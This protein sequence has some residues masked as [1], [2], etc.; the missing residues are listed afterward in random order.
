[1]SDAHPQYLLAGDIGGTHSLLE[2]SE[3]RGDSM[4][5]VHEQSYR[6]QAYPGLDALLDDFLRLPPVSVAAERVHAACFAVAG[7]VEANATRLSNLPWFIDGASLA[8]RYGI[9]QV[10]IVNDFAAVGHGIGELGA[11]ELTT[12]QP[13]AAHPGGTRLAVGAG[14]GLG[15]CL[16]TWQDDRYVVHPSEGG[17]ADFAPTN[18]TQDASLLSLRQTLGHVSYERVV[19]GPGL[20]RI[21]GF[22][23]ESGTGMPSSALL[24]AMQRQDPSAAISEFAIDRRDVLA[25]RALDLFVEIYGA[26][27]GSMALTTLARGGVYLAGGIARKIAHKLV[28]GTFIRTFTDKGRFSEL[29]RGCPVHIVTDRRVGL[30]GALS[31]IRRNLIGQTQ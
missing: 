16:M 20:L 2:L 10:V 14:T 31:L 22:L 24:E 25:G 26:F 18:S 19:S 8:A 29:L 30:R 17:H 1:M 5:S 11:R 3:R 4:R 12:L 13:G 21:F 9:S 23:Q 28:D 6:S 27:C 15:V 7:P